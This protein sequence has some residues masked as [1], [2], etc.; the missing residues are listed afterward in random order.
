MRLWIANKNYSSWSLRPW[1]LMR[2]LGIPFEERLHPFAAHAQETQERFRQFSPSGKVPCLEDGDLKIWD[3]LAITEYL[4]ETHPTVWPQD[5]TARAWARSAAAE[6]HSGFSALRRHC[7]MSCGQR[8][9]LRERA[10]SLRSDLA[11]LQELWQA[12]QRR[13]GGPFLAGAQFTAVDAFYAPVAFR[14]QSYQLD[15]DAVCDAY[16]DRLLAL[17][18]MQEWYTAALLEPW[19]EAAHEREIAAVAASIIDLRA[20]P[21]RTS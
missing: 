13:F 19:R 3:S 16:R 18:A 15:L 7:S 6:M 14:L 1:V 20:D 8:I 4:A 9:T 12:G 17:P 21:C 5:R 10:P 2:V 11:R